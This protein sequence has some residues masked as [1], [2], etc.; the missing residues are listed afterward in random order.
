M[1]FLIITSATHSIIDEKVLSYAP[2]VYEMN[3]W[4]KHCDEVVIVAPIKVFDEKD[5]N[6]AYNDQ[7][8]IKIISVREFNI[9]SLQSVIKAIFLSAYNFLII[10]KAMFSANHIHLRCPGNIGLLG[11][12]A[13]LFFPF[14]TKTAKYAG[15]WDLNVKQPFTYKLQKKILAST[16]T[17][18]MNVLVYGKWPNQSKNI[19]PFFT[20]TYS[21][22]EK[23]DVVKPSFENGISFVFA[24]MLVSGKNPLYA[25]KLVE[26]LR[27]KG[28][29]ANL[30]LY[31]EGVERH[32]LESYIDD[33]KLQNFVFLKGNQKADVVKNAY[34]KSHFVIL[35]SE[36]EGWPK[37]IAE[38][39]FWGAVPIVKPVSCVPFMVDYGNR[40]I[41]L[42]SD[43]EKDTSQ[44]QKLINDRNSF[45]VMSKNAASWSR[46]YTVE[47]F[48]AQIK[49]LLK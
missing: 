31:G 45:D 35:P 36:S 38:G 39:M 21:E 29:D 15:N 13:Q 26:N 22:G 11:C 9:K 48:E 23:T 6:I 18:N 8:K 5:L 46:E 20:A 30:S 16:F 33:Q 44:I 3:L 47:E 19:K 34:Q 10:F 43:L 28:Y 27:H 32:K 14:K 2:L 4:T 37:V 25:V 41:L 24:G 1:R 7:Q 17:R 12:F 40:G 49:R 42:E